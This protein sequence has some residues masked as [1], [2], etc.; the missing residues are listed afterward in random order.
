[1]DSAQLRRQGDEDL[2]EE[3]TWFKSLTTAYSI[4]FLQPPFWVTGRIPQNKS[5]DWVQA[6]FRPNAT[7]I[8]YVSITPW[9]RVLREKLTVPQLVKKFLAFYGTRRFITVFTTSHHLSLS[10]TRP[11]QSMSPQPISWRSIS[12]LSSLLSLVSSPQFSSL[13]FCIHLSPPPYLLHAP[14]ISFFFIFTLEKYL[15][16]NTED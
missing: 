14:L 7:V 9:N 2:C 6:N 8:K 13:K 12:I 10:W 16:R 15:V 11:N 1:M 5:C 4:T 3:E